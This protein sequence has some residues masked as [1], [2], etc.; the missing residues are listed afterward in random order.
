MFFV[1]TSEASPRSGG[2]LRHRDVRLDR[3]LEGLDEVGQ[4]RDQVLRIGL[5]AQRQQDALL[6]GAAV[7]VV[8][9]MA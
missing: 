4:A 5:L 1:S 7:E 9:A 8:G 3:R 6:A 2:E